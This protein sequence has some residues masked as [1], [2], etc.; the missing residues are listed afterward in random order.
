MDRAVLLL[1]TEE[2]TYTYGHPFSMSTLYWHGCVSSSGAIMAGSFLPG[3]EAS[4]V[5]YSE[6]HRSTSWS[7]AT[8]WS[9]LSSAY[10]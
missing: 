5:F 8:Q 1:T 3:C 10:I 6:S 9:F 2:P 4:W 7:P